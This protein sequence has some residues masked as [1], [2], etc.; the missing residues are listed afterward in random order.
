MKNITTFGIWG[1]TDKK[2]FWRVLPKILSWSNTKNLKP[3][4]TKRIIKHPNLKNKNILLFGLP[5]NR[6]KIKNK[7]W[8]HVN[9]CRSEDDPQWKIVPF[10]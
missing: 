7:M 1:N 10:G 5:E 6:T 4:L 2:S 8:V 3:S 9:L